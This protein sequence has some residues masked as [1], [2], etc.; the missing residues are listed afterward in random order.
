MS[1]L[2]QAIEQYLTLRRGLGFE[3]REAETVLRRFLAFAERE[4][5]SSITTDLVLRWT[6]QPS[7]AQPATWASWVAIVRRLAR[8]WSATDPRTEVPP[9][10]LLPHRF[11][12]QRPYIY[13]DDEIERLVRTAAQLPSA[14]GMRALTYSTFFGLVAATGMRIGEGLALDR[15]DVDLEEGILTVRRTKFAKSRLVPLHASTREAL[16]RYATQRNRIFRRLETPAFFV[17]EH[18]RRITQWSTRYHFAR[19]SQQVGLRA[20][21]GGH[22][23]GHGPRIHDLR[24]RFAVRTLIEWYRRGLDVEREIPKLATYLGHVHVNDTYWY[25]EAVPELLQLASERLMQQHQEELS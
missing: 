12:R 19:V 21:A 4:G 11:R 15:C 17:S 10:G 2:R 22:R 25:I 23:H 24:H 3:L 16:E 13:S 18:G 7:R 14:N 5:A 1:E 9:E 20:P 6:R 8:W